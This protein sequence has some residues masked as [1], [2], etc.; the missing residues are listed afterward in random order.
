MVALDY[1]KS[2][3]TGA[4]A[5]A[6]SAGILFLELL[7]IGT[8][9][10]HSID[11]ECLGNW[12]FCA[13]RGASGAMVSVFCAMGALAV[14][15]MLRPE[16]FR[17]LLTGASGALSGLGLNA[18]G[19][20]TALLPVFL[21]REGDGA[22]MLWPVL[23]I[24]AVSLTLI[25]VGLAVFVAPARRWSS[26]FEESWKIA[27][28]VT[29]TGLALPYLATIVRPAWRSVDFIA[30]A[31]F[32]TVA[33]ITQWLGYDIEIYPEWKTI[34]ADDFYINIAP[35]C[36]G[37]EGMALVTLFVT[38]FLRLFRS[39][40]R[41]P[42]AFLLYP[43]GL[44]ASAIFNVVRITVLL[45]IGLEGN[46]ELAVGGFHSHAGWLMFT[47]VSIGLIAVAQTVPWLRK[48]P[49]CEAPKQSELPPFRQDPIAAC[50]LPFAVFMLSALF[51]SAFA[52]QPAL[53]Y[54]LRVGAMSAALIV[55]WPV[56][57]QLIWRLDIPS[58]MIGAGIGL[59]WVLIPVENGPAPYGELA[60]VALVGWLIA[61][62]FGTIVLVPVIEELFFRKY[63]E[64]KLR[65]GNGLIWKIA[66][67]CVIAA[68]FAILHDR[69]IEAIVAS[70][71]FSYVMARRERV[72]DAITAHA[73]AN[74]I[75]FAGAVVVGN[76]SLI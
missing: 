41:F 71:A 40:L 55:F 36:S 14:A 11:F 8:V 37:I 18:V 69:W 75:V 48:A 25:V 10:K 47:I 6:I 67:A 13:C 12:P 30:E 66:A 23:G 7:L 73:V 45:V 63:L 44:L 57:A 49:V 19:V 54:P 27:V 5:L 28:P 20:G 53:A 51:V 9:F 2:G 43:V 72:E 59:M 50:I 22:A 32:V 29:V 74:A 16:P 34:G 76:L 38:I 21:L 17:S 31:T 60:G 1:S 64:R 56:L 24:W 52:S 58:V 42:R 46:P 33:S 65:I 3:L 26:F 15:L 62:G 61:R 35:V 70:F 39:D 68:I 4:R